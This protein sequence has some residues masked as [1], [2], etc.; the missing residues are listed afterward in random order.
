MIGATGFGFAMLRAD[1]T[2]RVAT[3]LLILALPIGVLLTIVFTMYMVGEGVDPW[4][5]PMVFYG[6]A[7]I[8]LGY[9]LRTGKQ[10]VKYISQTF[11]ACRFA[12][13]TLVRLLA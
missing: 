10:N 4:G 6:L 2:P 11:C 9:H 12:D 13:Y 1:A 5:G 3:W 8:V 7:W